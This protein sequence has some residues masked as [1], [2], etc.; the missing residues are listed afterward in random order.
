MRTKVT[1]SFEDELAVKASAYARQ[2]HTSVRSLMREFLDDLMD[3][4]L[5][6]NVWPTPDKQ[7]LPAIP[8]GDSQ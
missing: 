8:T 2:N 5:K 3:E 4:K 7:I 6:N 1:L